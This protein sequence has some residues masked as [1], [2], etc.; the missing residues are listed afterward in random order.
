M[1]CQ[2]CGGEAG[3]TFTGADGKT[4]CIPC[5]SKPKVDPA[6]AKV[7]NRVAVGRPARTDF[8]NVGGRKDFN[9]GFKKAGFRGGR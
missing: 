7:L 2:D 8:R 9:K 5:Y 3:T 1:K 6:A 4:V